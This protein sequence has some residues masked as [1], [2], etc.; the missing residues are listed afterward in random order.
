MVLHVDI[1]DTYFQKDFFK[2]Y[3]NKKHFI[4]VALEDGN[5]TDKISSSWMK[6][7]YGKEIFE[8]LKNKTIICSGTIWG[9]VDKF[10]ELTKNI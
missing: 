2:Y 6:N 7:Q 5:M 1:R 4:G 9:T 3:K 8:E 10:L